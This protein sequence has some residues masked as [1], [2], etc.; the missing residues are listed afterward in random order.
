VCFFFFKR[1][2]R[3]ADTG[4]AERVSQLCFLLKAAFHCVHFLRQ[5]H[6]GVNIHLILENVTELSSTDFPYLGFAKLINFSSMCEFACRGEGGEK[7]EH[8]ED[9]RC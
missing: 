5:D 9:H 1:I 3:F 7:D 2:C 8:F 6:C 4:I